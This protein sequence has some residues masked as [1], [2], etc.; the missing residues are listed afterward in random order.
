[1][2]PGG[3]FE[4]LMVEPLGILVAFVKRQIGQ[5][6]SNTGIFVGRP[7]MSPFLAISSSLAIEI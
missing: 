5:C 4:K 7:F 3:N 1:M 6:S 2:N